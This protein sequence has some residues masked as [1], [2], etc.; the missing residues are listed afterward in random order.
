MFATDLE[1]R[2]GDQSK[3]LEEISVFVFSYDIDDK[4]NDIKRKIRR[5]SGM[6]N[7]ELYR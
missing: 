2:M 5:H 4:G 6:L 7:V 1:E 3:L